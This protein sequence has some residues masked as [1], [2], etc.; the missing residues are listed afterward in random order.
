MWVLNVGFRI[1]RLLWFSYLLPE[2]FSHSSVSCVHVHA[3]CSDAD[4]LLIVNRWVSFD[5]TMP[6]CKSGLRAI[7]VNLRKG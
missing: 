4:D 7:L 3:D 6:S 5:M 2:H 1:N